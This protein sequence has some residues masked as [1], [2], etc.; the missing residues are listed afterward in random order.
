MIATNVL[1]LN[2]RLRQPATR[3]ALNSDQDLR[4]V[5]EMYDQQCSYCHGT[6]SG[7]VAP[8]AR[9][10]SPRPPQ[11]AIEASKNPTWMDAFAVRH[12]IRWSA[13][14]A[15][16]EISEDDAWRLALYVERVN[17]PD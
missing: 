17:Q 8:L 14:P 9:S 13:M 7:G 11:F 16:R 12:G 3:K 2:I 6:I 1:A 15:F 10:F 4:A 5:G